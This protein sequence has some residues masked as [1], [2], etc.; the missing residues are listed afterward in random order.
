[1]SASRVR[2]EVC[3]T[4]G[5]E[6][7]A[8]AA[9]GADSVEL[10]SWLAVGGIT[11][12]IGLVQEVRQAVRIPVRVLVRPHGG[13]LVFDA[14]DRAVLLRDVRALGDLAAIVTGGNT[15]AGIPDMPLLQ[16]VR[17]ALPAQELTFHRAIDHTADLLDAFN[18]CAAAG[19]QRVLTSGGASRA[20]DGAAML[21]RLVERSSGTGVRVAAAGGIGPDN[22]VRLVELTGVR[23]VH[24]AAQ[25]AVPNAASDK[26]ALSSSHRPDLMA[27]APD[28]RKIEGVMEALTKAGLR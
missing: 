10:C 18:R 26:A 5:A 21:K 13:E 12:S 14:T 23:E 27:F 1:M 6:A 2:V 8:A 9:L 3:V 15:P 22:V 20:L 17:A 28:E 11:P 16:E 25:K 24:F 7:R 4:S 19:V